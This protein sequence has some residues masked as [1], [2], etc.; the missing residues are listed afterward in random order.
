[1]AFTLSTSIA[2][3]TG[4]PVETVQKIL[5]SLRSIIV[6]QAAIGESTVIRGI[7]TI[8]PLRYK[9]LTTQGIVSGFTVK[10]VTSRNLQDDI[11]STSIKSANLEQAKEN[12]KNMEQAML[13]AGIS[14]MEIP[15]LS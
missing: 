8:K 13:D 4:Y 3:N 7:A 6:E 9:Q 14:I 12:A 10:C 1:M 5:D 11:E 15:G 2:E